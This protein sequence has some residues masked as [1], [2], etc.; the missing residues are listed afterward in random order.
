M[1]KNENK[2]DNIFI[3]LSMSL[4]NIEEILAVS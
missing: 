4:N 2:K 3:L 1:L